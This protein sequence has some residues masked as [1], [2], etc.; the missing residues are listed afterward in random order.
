MK[1]R[2]AFLMLILLWNGTAALA[3]PSET[4]MASVGSATSTTPLPDA[5][6]FSMRDQEA[7]G[8]GRDLAPLNLLEYR[9]MPL[10]E[11]VPDAL[12]D[13]GYEAAGQRV[14]FDLRTGTE[15]TQERPLRKSGSS[16]GQVAGGWGE[17]RGRSAP[18]GSKNFSSL[19]WVS[20]PE[21]YPW[22]VAVKLFMKFRDTTG[23][24]RGYVCS[25]SLIDPQHVVTAGH[26]VYSHEDSDNGWVFNDWAEEITVVPGY[27]NGARP[28]GDAVAVQLHSY[29]GWTSSADFDYDLGIIDLDRPIGAL[30]GW[31]GYG[32]YSS[33]DSYT[34]N[35]FRHAGYPQASPYDGQ[36]LYTN[37]GTYDGCDTILGAWFGNEVYFNSRSYG[38]QS[39]SG[40]YLP[41][42]QCPNC[43]VTAVLSNGNN[44]YT[45][46]VR[47]DEPKFDDIGSIIGS[48]TPA[49][50]D[51]AVLDVNVSPGTVSS[52]SQ[53]TSMNY[54]VHNYSSSSWSGTVN[55]DVY[56]S[57]NDIIS[58]GDTFLQRHSFTYSLGAKS[59]VRITV[60]VPPTIPLGRP[61]G[62]YWIGAFLDFTDASGS[63]NYSDGQDAAPITISGTPSP[64]VTTNPATS[65]TQTSA[66]LNASVNPNGSS[67]T[68][69]FEWG[70]TVAYGN[71]PSY[72]TV[73]NATTAQSIGLSLSNLA[74]G[75]LYH[76]RARA[77]NAGGTSYGSDRTFTTAACSGGS[78]PDTTGV[79]RPSNGALYLKNQNTSGFAN[80]YLTYGIAGDYPVAGDW[81]GDGIDTIGVYRNGTFFLR[82]SNTNGIANLA[83]SFG[84]AGDQPVVGDWNGDGVDTIGVFRNGTFF[85]RN[86]NSSGSADL[87]FSLGIAGDVGIAGDWNGD[88]ITTTG[89]FRPTNGALYLKNANSTGFADLVLTYG[90]PGDRPVTGDWDGDGD[91][92][93][94]V[95][96]NGTF[97]LRNSNTNG[98]AQLVFSLGVNGD[99]PIAGDWD[100]LP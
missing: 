84:A 10:P 65:V 43:W 62:N 91:D 40:S 58:S 30:A 21:V 93:I 20:T 97:Y 3:Q 85:L 4:E 23:T 33:C 59:S 89:V 82:N 95:Y 29:V 8:H 88:G 12:S 90:L 72:G 45:N 74:C 39:G 42:D 36:Y 50:V 63:N 25:G 6:S 56:L 67:T 48:D 70:L 52:G 32:W 92:T 22:S 94:G 51:L 71:A 31:H 80:L 13:E 38:G 96:R 99:I 35:T 79:F 98:F 66:Q 5:P 81:N 87:I 15:A 78:N 46:D 14:S 49:S 69:V 83:F 27:E 1:D 34:G 64:T 26:C 60:S 61:A 86:S 68:A 9:P 41:H 28:Y 47:I 24:L 19:S 100:G 16:G 18:D 54:L 76:F 57:T 55:V 44:S 7:E 73:G 53:L 75:T 77:T 11:P 2:F 17:R 37:A